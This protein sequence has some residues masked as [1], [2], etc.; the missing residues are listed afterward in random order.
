MQGLEVTHVHL[1]FLFS[2][3][4]VKYPCALVHWFLCVGDQ[5]DNTGMWTVEPG[6]SD[7]SKTVVFIIHLD[8]IV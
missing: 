4:G 2:H 6:M 7:D 1:F 3:E 8:T 5:W